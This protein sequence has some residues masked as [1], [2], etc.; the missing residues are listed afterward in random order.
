MYLTEHLQQ[1]S[2]A[3]SQHQQRPF[4]AARRLAEQNHIFELS[5]LL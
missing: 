4:T 1:T 3:V 5:Y 2:V